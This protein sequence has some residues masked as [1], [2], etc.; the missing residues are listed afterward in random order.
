MRK[1]SVVLEHHAEATVLGLQLVNPAS[2][3]IDTAAGGAEQT[4]DAI[5]G[6]QFAAAGWA[7]KRYELSLADR[8]G[9]S[10]SAR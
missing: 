8:P 3:D 6:R 2:I 1:Q 4:G 5:E 7:E 9:R 10:G